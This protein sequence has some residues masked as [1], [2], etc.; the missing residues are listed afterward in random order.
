MTTEEERATGYMGYLV[1]LAAVA[2]AALLRLML[3]PLLGNSVPYMTF[4]P[5]TVFAAWFAG[6]GPGY[7]AAVT[8]GTLAYL[9]L[10]APTAANRQAAPELLAYGLFLGINIFTSR[11]TSSLRSASAR[12]EA[13]GAA[14]AESEERMR[15]GTEAAKMGAWTRDLRTEAVTWSPQLAAVFGI[16]PSEFG[17]TRQS[18]LDL[19]VAEDR[20]RIAEAVKQAIENCSDYEV[21][22]RF[23][24]RDGEER[25]MLARGRTYCDASGTPVRLAGVGIDITERK[26]AEE[27]LRASEERYRSLIA[28]TSSIVWT[29]D[30]AG[31]FVEPQPMWEEFTGQS[32]DIHRGS[33]WLEAIHEEDRDNVERRWRRALDGKTVFESEG[34][35]WH[36]AFGQHRHFVARAVPVRNGDGSV[37]E[38][39]GALTDIEE[40]KRLDQKLLHA[41]KLDSLGVLA[42]G[43]AHD[44]NN[45][46]VGIMGN[47]SILEEAVT[48]GSEMAEIA[49]AIVQASERAAHLTRQ[50]LAYAGKGRFVVRHVDLSREV[51]DLLPLLEPALHHSVE[52]RLE[53]QEGLPLVKSD[54]SQIQQII[55]N[56]VINAAEATAKGG[57]VTVSTELREDAR[58]AETLFGD[59]VPG[60]HPYVILRVQD[61]GHG[62]DEA[63]R[64][65]IFDP[66]YST[67]FTGRGLGLAAVLGIVRAHHGGIQVQS[68]PGQGSSFTVYLPAEAASPAPVIAAERSAP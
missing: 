16:A 50:M 4:F 26:L 36:A 65:R 19:V 17:G 34:R 23:I 51:R 40:R 31:T 53:L 6:A 12:A 54:P 9:L 22:F 60:N 14:L 45:L 43:I 57:R 44:F 48:P 67:K 18:Y 63:T 59:D 20:P 66:F 61:T 42:G 2:L 24:R 64:N 47:A 58:E 28:A 8:G 35:V 68:A 10:A 52:L 15:L 5:A 13:D 27:A 38:W 1:S 30:A 21:V 7:L 37:R 11:L 32:W 29:T 39:I 46:L 62:M 25:W 55:M 49:A 56:L 41:D 33:G 3:M